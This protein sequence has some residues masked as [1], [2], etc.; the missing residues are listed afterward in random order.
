MHLGGA[1]THPMVGP[2][3]EGQG[4]CNVPESRTH[5]CH[6][7]LPPVPVTHLPRLQLGD[8]NPIAPSWAISTFGMGRDGDP[9]SPFPPAGPARAGR[10]APRLPAHPDPGAGIAA[11]PLPLQH[12]TSGYVCNDNFSTGAQ[13]PPSHPPAVSTALTAFPQLSV[14]PSNPIRPA[15]TPSPTDCPGC[16]HLPQPL[17]QPQ[18]APPSRFDALPAPCRAPCSFLCLCLAPPR[19][20]PAPSR[21][22][23]RHTTEPLPAEA[24][25]LSARGCGESVARTPPVSTAR[26]CWPSAPAWPLA[27]VKHLWKHPSG[28]GDAGAAG[29]GRLEPAGGCPD[30]QAAGSTTAG[31]PPAPHA[32]AERPRP[33]GPRCYCTF[34]SLKR[35]QFGAG[36]KKGSHGQGGGEGSRVPLG[37]GAGRGVC[38]WAGGGERSSLL[39]PVCFPV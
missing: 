32:A 22:Q 21:P 9:E 20:T 13:L 6:L 23:S 11:L 16:S 26:P 34:L 29:T 27:W 38:T 1:E 7:M 30:R 17:P 19:Q 2:S 3:P 10:A 33:R 14:K 35:H 36:S 37:R 39:D 5:D 24:R 15:A 4:E 12:S 25:P 8:R 28:S 18:P 31:S